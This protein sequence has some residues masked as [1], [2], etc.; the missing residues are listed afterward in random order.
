MRCP[1]TTATSTPTARTRREATSA[2]A[3]LVSTVTVSCAMTTM[4]ASSE[5]TCATSSLLAPTNSELTSATVTRATTATASPV[6]TTTIVWKMT[7]SAH[8]DSASTSKEASSA[9]VLKDTHLLMTEKHVKV[10]TK[11][12]L[13]LLF[14]INYRN[15]TFEQTFRHRWVRFRAHLRQR[16]VSQHS[17]IFQMRLSTWVSFIVFN[18]DKQS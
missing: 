5:P 14:C 16:K 18:N 3:S 2:N 1:S 9:T 4:S 12:L 11:N 7:A 13:V 17:R 10:R 8:P 6:Q 15:F